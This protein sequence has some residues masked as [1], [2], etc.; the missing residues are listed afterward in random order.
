MSSE[1]DVGRMGD[2]VRVTGSIT[3][4]GTA[5]ITE[6]RGEFDD[7]DSLMDGLRGFDDSLDD[8]GVSSF[9]LGR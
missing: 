6:E 3:P 2:N 4:G 1:V 9:D 5:R 8:S 7:E